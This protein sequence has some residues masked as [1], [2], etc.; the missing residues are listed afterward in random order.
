MI[1]AISPRLLSTPVHETPAARDERLQETAREFEAMF[2]GILLKQMRASTRALSPEKVSFAREM[3]EGWQDEMFA[4]NMSM[5]AGIGLAAVLY[6]QL[7]QEQQAK[8]K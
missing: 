1:D 2:T 3:Y 4:R 6:R 5:G 7:R 8:Q